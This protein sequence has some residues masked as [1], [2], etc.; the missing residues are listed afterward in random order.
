[1]I[2]DE[3]YLVWELP[4]RRWFCHRCILHFDGISFPLNS[5]LFADPSTYKL[6]SHHIRIKTV[7]PARCGPVKLCCCYEYSIN[8]IDLTYVNDVDVIGEPAPCPYRVCCCASGKDHVEIQTPTERDGNVSLVLP[9]GHGEKV[10]SLILNQIE[11]AQKI[12][13]D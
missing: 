6:T 4:S 1:M 12:E 5:L 8:N 7:K 2:T 9:Q 3:H 13:R 10:S 11:E